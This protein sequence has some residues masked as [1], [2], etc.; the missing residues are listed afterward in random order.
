VFYNVYKE[1]KFP[2]SAPVRI[3]GWLPREYK[4]WAPPYQQEPASRYYP[5]G[6]TLNV[7]RVVRRAAIDLK[8]DREGDKESTITL[9]SG[10]TPAFAKQRVRLDLYDPIGALR[11][12]EVFTENNGGFAATFD[13]RY[14]PSLEADRK[15]WK[16][17]VA[18]RTTLS[19]G[20]FN[21]ILSWNRV[22]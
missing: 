8:E 19:L 21:K 20:S 1:R 15:N 9:R 12:S 17:S 5:I 2:M 4:E 7:V 22:F 14:E 6:G 18:G 16:K 10:I 13:L 3:T 11:V